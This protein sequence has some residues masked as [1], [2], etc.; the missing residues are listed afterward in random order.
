MP[1]IPLFIFAGQSNM[2]GNIWGNIPAPTGVHVYNSAGIANCYGPMQSF[3]EQMQYSGFGEM[4]VARAAV[5]GTTLSQHET[6][7]DWS[8]D[9][10]NELYDLLIQ[11]ISSAIHDLESQGYTVEIQGLF[12]M[13]GESDAGASRCV[14]YEGNLTEF[15]NSVRHDLGV[16]DL[17]VYLGE[18]AQRDDV[19]GSA[20]VR[21]AQISV[22]NTLNNVTVINT[23]GSE[24]RD[25]GWH[26]SEAGY[27]E[28]GE[29]FANAYLQDQGL[30]SADITQHGTDGD[31]I[32]QISEDSRV[33]LAGEGDDIIYGSLGGEYLF[34][35]EGNDTIYARSGND[36][37]FGGNG[38]DA[39]VGGGGNDLLNGGNGNDRLYGGEGADRLYG[40]EGNDWFDGGAGSDVI[41]GGLGTN[42]VSYQNSL[43]G[44]NIN[45]M[46]NINTGGDA[47]GDRLVLIQNVLGSDLNDIVRADAANN[48]F[49]GLAGNDQCN[50]KA[51]ND[52]L[53]G[54]DGRDYLEGGKGDDVVY[55]G[56]GNDCFGFALSAA[57]ILNPDHD[58]IQDFDFGDFIRMQNYDASDLAFTHDGNV[59]TIMLHN[60]DR[61][62]VGYITI[63]TASEDLAATIQDQ[64]RYI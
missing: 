59:A 15:I 14:Q 30:D 54:G 44:V 20:I 37:L 61:D 53:Y 8:P 62:V 1:T 60:A 52:I 55:G 24:M 19:P 64:I 33:V 29:S 13:Q 5:G 45:L 4:A 25:D 58:I 35:E 38:D 56:A 26:F 48:I 23:D 21:D 32:I 2:V 18:I 47:Q 34:G 28:M 46:S 3:V 36:Q 27:Y 41:H 17:P 10:N 49:Q 7:M 42:T 6:A 57:D 39:L 31:D 51:G 22:A 12:W 43:A 50:G 11:T 40:W 9:S 16:A 63:N